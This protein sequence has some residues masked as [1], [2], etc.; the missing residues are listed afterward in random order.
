MAAPTS[1][2]TSRYL[3]GPT[4]VLSFNAASGIQINQGDLCT[5]HSGAVYPVSEYPCLS[6]AE[7]QTWSGAR[8]VFL[9]VA[10]GNHSSLTIVSGQHQVPVLVEGLVR[11]PGKIASGV[12]YT[13]GTFVS[14]TQDG[15]SGYF[16]PQRIMQC[17][18]Q[19][20]AIGKIA[21]TAYS[22][23]AG[24]G[25]WTIDFQGTVTVGTIGN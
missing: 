19:A 10:Q 9:G 1:N 8:A 3:G 24:Q 15:N 4:T 23:A 17:S 25:E 7:L 22:P 6:G 21:S 18:G 12:T 14:F 13:P 16:A 11:M 20:T 2:P 5:F